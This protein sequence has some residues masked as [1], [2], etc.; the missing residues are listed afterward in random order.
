MIT[1]NSERGLVRIMSWDD[2]ESVP[3][4]TSDID[5][6]TVKLKEIIGSYTF[7]AL[8]PC[9]LSTCHQPH[10]NGFLVAAADGR[11]TNIGRI[12]GKK[13]FNVEFTHMSRIFLAAV[14]AQQS[15]EFLGE[16]KNRLPG[17]S[18]EVATIKNGQHGAAWIN[19]RVN[20]LT[21]SSAALPTSIV[22]AV[23]QAVRRGDGTLIIERAATKKERE[24]RFAAMD[25][26]GLEHLRRNVPFVVED[27]VGQLDGFPAL[28]PGNGLREVL[29]TIEP[30][31]TALKEA[32]IESL[33]DK[34]LRELTKAGGELDA[35]LERLRSIITAG[36]RLLKRRNIQQ[37]T[38]FATSSTDNRL[39]VAFLRDLPN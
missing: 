31:L 26:K 28:A 30:F 25:V 13:H 1:L 7:D 24:E 15:R 10:G 14:R 16:L 8:I 12:C 4:F 3:G 36:R 37:L 29:G 19:A 39:F 32:D 5:P 9:G 6:K 23:R 17:I 22:N 20:Q 11:V 38:R 35:N 2:I 18:A 21:G 34:Q 33:S 27:R